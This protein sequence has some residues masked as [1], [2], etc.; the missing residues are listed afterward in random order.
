MPP[1][2]LG[3]A[4][5]SPAAGIRCIQGAVAQP[6]GE[7]RNRPHPPPPPRRLLPGS[8]PVKRSSRTRAG[9]SR[10]RSGEGSGV[11]ATKTRARSGSDS[12][13]LPA[14]PAQCGRSPPGGAAGPRCEP[15]GGGGAPRALSGSGGGPQTV[16][17]PASGF[18]ILRRS[19][20][21]C[22]SSTLA[23][24]QRTEPSHQL[25]SLYLFFGLPFPT[26]FLGGIEL[27]EDGPGEVRTV[28]PCN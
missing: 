12:R 24:A 26:C 22:W 2:P 23:G 17:G 4:Q 1:H 21:G 6:G 3:S 5:V 19:G 16:R 11:R 7:P 15:R 8:A 9:F 28:S 25:H 14:G 20:Q 13:T 10:R 27:W 18:L